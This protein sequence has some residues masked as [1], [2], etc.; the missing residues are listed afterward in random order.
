MDNII[1]GFYIASLRYPL[2]WGRLVRR[3]RH[4]RRLHSTNSYVALVLC[5]R[6]V[7]VSCVDSSVAEIINNEAFYITMLF[8]VHISFDD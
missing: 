2:W 4:G 7:V 5:F 1:C 3:G 6:C 8:A